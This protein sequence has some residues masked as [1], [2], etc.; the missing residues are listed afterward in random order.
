MQTILRVVTHIYW[1]K[2]LEVI[3]REIIPAAADL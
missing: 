2:P 1:I 3:G